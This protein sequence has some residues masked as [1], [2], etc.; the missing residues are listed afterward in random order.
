MMYRKYKPKKEQRDLS[1]M[2]W[3]T[4]PGDKKGNGMFKCWAPTFQELLEKI[5][6]VWAFRASLEQKK[7]NAR[8]ITTQTPT[9]RLPGY[10]VNGEPRT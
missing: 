2:H 7:D 5:D 6:A 1:L 10:T 3:Y 8:S 4:F 9:E